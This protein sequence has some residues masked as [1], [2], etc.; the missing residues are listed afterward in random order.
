MRKFVGLVSACCLLW[1]ISGCASNP[2]EK[3]LKEGVGIID[4]MKASYDNLKTKLTAAQD[5][6]DK[7]VKLSTEKAKEAAVPTQYFEELEAEAK[8]LQKAAGRLNVLRTF[9]E[10]EKEKTT[11]QER[12]RLRDQFQGSVQSS[13]IE[14]DK[15]KRDMDRKFKELRAAYP[16]RAQDKE[17]PSLHYDLSIPFGSSFVES[18]RTHVD[19]VEVYLTRAEQEFDKIAQ[20]R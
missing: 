18:L 10:A 3:I 16:R 8:E 4:S 9:T 19:R 17:F 13:L 20:Q 15:S 6:I 5:A 1:G 14:L 11:P 7:E 2:Q 12:N